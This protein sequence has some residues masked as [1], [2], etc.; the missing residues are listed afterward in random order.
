MKNAS[1][2]AAAATA[3][4]LPAF[5]DDIT[6]DTALQARSLHDGPADMTVYYQPAAETG[7][8]EVTATYAPRDGS[9]APGRLVLRL[10]N[11]DGVSFALPGIQDVTYSFAR[12]ADTVTVRATPALKTASVE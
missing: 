4:A 8:V 6:L 9:R 10:R 11:G 12:A 3:F 1:L 2:L 7:F 5:A